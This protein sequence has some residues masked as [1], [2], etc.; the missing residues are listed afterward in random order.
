MSAITAELEQ[1][2]PQL[3]ARTKAFVERVIREAIELA[4]SNEG[5]TLDAN[6]YP[7]GYFESTFGSFAH[8]PLER[9]PQSTLECREDW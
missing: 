7:P 3:D 4:K 2:L 1:A 9:A 8:E 5:N 6:G